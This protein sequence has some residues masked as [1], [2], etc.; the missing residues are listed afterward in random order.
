MKVLLDTHTVL[1]A[2]TQPALLSDSVRTVLLDDTTEVLVSSAVAWELSIKH[3]GGKLPEAGPLL[4]DYPTVIAALV[5]DVLPISP[6]HAI[7]A[8]GLQW[9][10]RDP[11]DRMLAAQSMTEG[12][13]LISR[14]EAFDTLPG[15]R[16]FW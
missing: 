10:H 3:H 11:F 13:I 6:G 12:A 8:G 2:M 1:W 7:L 14:D 16:R 15:V 5:A 9:A 4:A